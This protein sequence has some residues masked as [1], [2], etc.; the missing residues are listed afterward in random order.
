MMIFPS[1]SNRDQQINSFH[2]AIQNIV[3]EVSRYE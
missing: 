1:L 2:P 3:F